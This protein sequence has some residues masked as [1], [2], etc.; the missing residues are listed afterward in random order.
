MKIFLSHSSKD[1]TIVRRIDKDLTSHGFLTWIDEDEIPHGASI[2][3]SIQTGLSECQVLILFVSRHSVQS[4]WVTTEWESAISRSL[5]GG[6]ARVISVRLDDSEVPE[7]L[8][9]YR[10]ADFRERD[11]YEKQLSMLLNTLNLYRS[12]FQE[13]YLEP[14][15]PVTSVL[16][17]TQDLLDD[18]D[19]EFV[20]MPVHKRLM[21]VDTL[22]KIPR[23]G[24]KVRLDKFKPVVK[25][26][27][28]YDH[29]LSLA[30]SADC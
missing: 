3:A 17:F 24:K 16:E 8:R 25:I 6:G 28:V 19:S 5:S 20:S 15:A 12:E 1:K 23:S 21:L 30:H 4:K 29:I 13:A 2:P 14:R 10:Y 18:L 27:S 22:K 9:H 11:E 26:R 7:F